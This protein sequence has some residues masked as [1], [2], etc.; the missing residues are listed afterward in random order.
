MLAS[1][2]HAGEPSNGED[3]EARRHGDPG[4]GAAGGAERHRSGRCAGAVH[5]AD[6]R[7][8]SG[9]PTAAIC[10]GSQRQ[11]AEDTIGTGNVGRLERRGSPADTGYQSPA[12]I[13]S[14]GCVFINT[15]G[16]IEALDLET[17]ET[18]WQ[19]RGADTSGTFAVT[20]VDG[21]VHVGLNNG[22]RPK[23]AAFD[24]T[25]GQ[26][27]WTSDEIWFGYTTSQQASA[28]V[29]DGIQ[30]LF[31]TGPGLRSAGQAGLRADRRRHG[32]DPLQGDDDPGGGPRRGVRRRRRVGHARRSIPTPTTCTSAR[33]TLS[34]RPRSTRTTTRSSSSTSTAAV[35][36]SAR[37]SA[38]SRARPTAS[39]ATTTRSARASATRRGSTSAPTARRRLCGQLDV[40]FGDRSDP[41]AQRRRPP[42]RA[43]PR[44]SRAGCTCSTPRR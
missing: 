26:L 21:R 23:A 36:R 44:R 29:H 15:N 33:P 39:P 13:V 35:R 10:H 14:G 6:G 30:V 40:D 12:P 9:P 2:E 7:A 43:R 24:V 4:V 22:G 11:D 37:S 25:D 8:A 3:L 27:L 32:R 28:I 34:R 18:V 38:R 5:R 19:S 31:T 1:S 42:A 16:H 17:G 41:V 20:V